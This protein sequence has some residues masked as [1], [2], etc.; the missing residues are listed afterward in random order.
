MTKWLGGACIH[1]LLHNYKPTSCPDGIDID[2]DGNPGLFQ[3]KYRTCVYFHG[4]GCLCSLFFLFD[5]TFF[6]IACVPNKH[7][8]QISMCPKFVNKKQKIDKK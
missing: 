2:K 4:F 1:T 5:K 8:S 7:V 3:L 6:K